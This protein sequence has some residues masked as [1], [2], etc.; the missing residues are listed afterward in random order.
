MVD[1][2]ISGDFVDLCGSALD[3]VCMALYG[4]KIRSRR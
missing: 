2:L 1:V 4:R 3:R